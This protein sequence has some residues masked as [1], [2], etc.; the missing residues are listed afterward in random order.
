MDLL[1]A[2]AKLFQSMAVYQTSMPLPNIKIFA[3]TR[4]GKYDRNPTKN[5]RV[6][7]Q[8]ENVGNGL[9]DVQE[10][11]LYFYDKKI[12]NISDVLNYNKKWKVGKEFKLSPRIYGANTKSAFC[13]IYPTNGHENDEEWYDDFLN[14]LQ[15]HD[16]KVKVKYRS[17]FGWS[18]QESISIF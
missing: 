13:T 15:R 10:I 4:Q 1:N 7:L 6:E 11:D 2:V 5:P 18:K 3:N 9:L 8:F 17:V 16:V 14:T 12:N